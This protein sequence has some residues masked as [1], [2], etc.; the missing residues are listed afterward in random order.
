M[1]TRTI[2]SLIDDLDGTQIGQGDG[3]TVHFALDGAVYEIDLTSANAARLRSAF[4]QYV[5]KGRRVGGRRSAASSRGP[6]ATDRAQVQAA[7]AWLKDRGH[8][9][10][11]KG[12][13]KGELMDLYLAEAGQ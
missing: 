10:S 9:V 4:D 13:I 8:A 6:A 12:R 11:D 7:R 3:E 2:V 1:A 5:N